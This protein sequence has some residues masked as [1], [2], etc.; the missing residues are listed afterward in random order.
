MEQLKTIPIHGKEYVEVKTRVQYFRKNY[1]NGSIVT[2]VLQQDNE[3]ITTQ[4]KIFID[5]KLVSSGIAHEDK[6][7]SH[8]NKT[9]FI[10]CCETS[11]VGRALGM[12]GIG[13]ES[14]VDTADTI[15]RAIDQQDASK[16][17]EDLLNYKAEQLGIQLFNAINEDDEDSIKAIV[18]EMRGDQDLHNKVKAGLSVEHAEYMEDRNER[19]AEERKAK[20]AE[21][22][23]RN[24]Q[25]AKEY[26][27]SKSA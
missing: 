17:V 6:N 12:L 15:R 16:K 26:A 25:H 20:K 21:K 19:I 9:S 4:T 5:D 10:E 22:A 11:S 18:S 14:S 13:I 23:A 24:K 3:S 1:P 2:D 7:V 27:E 8:I